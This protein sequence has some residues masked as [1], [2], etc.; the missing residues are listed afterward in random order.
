MEGGGG[1]ETKKARCRVSKGEE[2][3]DVNGISSPGNRPGTT[4]NVDAA[5]A[6]IQVTYMYAHANINVC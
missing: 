6:C 2:V 4:Y 5:A 3:N 1:S